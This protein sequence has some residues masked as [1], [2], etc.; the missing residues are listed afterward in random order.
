MSARDV[1]AKAIC[2]RWFGGN[3]V[4]ADD[5]AIARIAIEALTAAGY[6]ILGPDDLDKVTVE[7]FRQEIERLT[8]HYQSQTATDAGRR[9][10]LEHFD[11][12]SLRALT[13]GEDD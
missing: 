2:Q 8:P 9:Q 1:I 5:R 13:G 12:F 11:A 6:R 10:I 3:D 4:D 7:R